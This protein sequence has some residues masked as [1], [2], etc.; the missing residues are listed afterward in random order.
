MARTKAQALYWAQRM[1]GS[2]ARVDTWRSVSGKMVRAVG[3]L[4]WGPRGGEGSSGGKHGAIF[5]EMGRGPTWEV[6]LEEAEKALEAEQHARA[7][8]ARAQ[9]SYDPVP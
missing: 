4:T 7:E 2:Q 1:L 5:K 8:A 6:A 9:A 3:V